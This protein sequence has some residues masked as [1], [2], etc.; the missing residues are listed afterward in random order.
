MPKPFHTIRF[1][2]IDGR[3]RNPIF[4]KTQL[5]FLYKTLSDHAT[6]I[7]QSIARDTGHTEAEVMAQYWLALGLLAEA[8]KAIEPKRALSDEY[9]VARGEN[10]ADGKGPVGIVVIRPATHAFFF[11]LLSALVPALA[12]GNCIIVQVCKLAV[13]KPPFHLSSYPKH[14]DDLLV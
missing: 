12:A 9:A 10:V 4:R 3:L 1:A 14:V 7:R 11:C 13:Y 2:A 5:E 6:D 8:Y